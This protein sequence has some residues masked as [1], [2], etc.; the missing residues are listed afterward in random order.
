[1]MGEQSLQVV[2]TPA[3]KTYSTGQLAVAIRRALEV[4]TAETLALRDDP[5]T[6][7]QA[8][9][10]SKSQALLELTRA[11]QALPPEALDAD[12]E[13]LLQQLKYALDDNMALLARHLDAVGEI[14]ELLA[15][16]ILEAES[17]GTYGR[18][19][20]ELGDA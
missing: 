3:R 6:G 8:F 15:E 10:Y 11:R 9:E 18:P 14:A 4:V 19:F 5:S 20:T 7:L 13:D 1:M 16:A 2:P 17:D 12:I